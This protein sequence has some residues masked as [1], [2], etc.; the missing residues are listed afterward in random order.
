[1]FRIYL[2]I[3]L[4]SASFLPGNDK[5]DTSSQWSM[6]RG[7]NASGIQDNA[8]L[9]S[10][11]DTET[12]KNIRW[13]IEIP[14]LGN[15]S[16]VVWDDNLFVTTAVGKTDTQKVVTGI[17]G[18]INPVQ[19]ESEQDWKLI[20][21]DKNSGKI[22]WEKTACSGVPKVKRHPMSTHANC[23]P[24]TN[25]EFVV[26]FFGSEGLYCF[27][28]KGNMKWKKDFGI[29]ESV[30]F[31]VPSAEWE[32]ASSPL[33][34]NNRV[35]IQCDVMKNSFLAAF[36]LQTGTQIWKKERDEYPGWCTPAIYFEGE[37]ARIAVNG[38][39]HRGGYD[40]ETGEELWRMAG[41]GDI[42][43]PTPVFSG[44][45]IY[46][47][48]AH[49]KFSPIMAVSVNARGDL[50]LPEGQTS[51]EF[52]K[53]S[54]PRGGSY[55]GTMLH[56][57]DYLYNSNWNGRLVCFNSQTGQEVYAQKAGT[58]KSYTSSP[59][60]SDGIIYITDNEGTVYSVK[61]G[62]EFRILAENKLHETIMSTPA[63][64]KGF[65]FF[66]TQN[67]LVAVSDVQR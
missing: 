12:G 2:L 54:L 27:D 6:Y 30:F 41:G 50:T 39:K 51:G 49:G 66:R 32:F 36:D 59:V 45:T 61:A 37:K 34:Y 10:E 40:F 62:P 29:L 35:I 20:C 13:K 14:G 17:Y 19:N 46:F 60:A 3:V 47:N 7:N 65:L 25:G 55:M 16:P 9:P 18:S 5:V 1:M 53:W 58:G 38:F 8:G 42:P 44:N 28:M 26:T 52:V 22:N 43:I 64:T 63:I 23:T 21:I 56:Y 48:S 11:W 31:A 67:H 4:F 57:G 15:S 24:A 33:I